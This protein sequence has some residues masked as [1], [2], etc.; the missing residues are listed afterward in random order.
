M[1]SPYRRDI[2]LLFATRPPYTSPSV[3]LPVP[4]FSLSSTQ[5]PPPPL[6][7]LWARRGC[8]EGAARRGLRGEGQGRCPA[9]ARALR[10]ARA[11][12]GGSSALRGEGAARGLQC[13]TARARRGGSTAR[14]RRANRKPTMDATALQYENQKLVQQLEAQ[15]SEMRTL[16]GKFKELRDEQCSYDNTLISLN[17]K[18]NQLIDDLVLLGVRAGGGLNNLQALDHEELSE[19]SLVSCPSEEIFL[20]R[21]LNSSNFRNNDENNLSEFV[22]E[23]LAL[24]YSTTV[25]L[26][27]SLQEAFAIQQARS[28]SLS[29]ALN[30]QNSNEG[31]DEGDFVPLF[32]CF[33]T[34]LH[35]LPITILLNCMFLNLDVIV[36]LEDHNE[37]LKEV[38]DNLHQAISI[39]NEKHGRYLDEIETFKSNHSRELQG[40]KCLSGE[41]EE[42]MA[43]LEESRR[44]LAV[45]Q[46]QRNGGSLVNTSA[47]NGVNGSVSTD[48]SSDKGT[49]WRDL[50]DAVEEAKTLA[51]NR[52]FE[53]HETQEDNLILSKQLEDL[54]DQLKD[55]KYIFMS[56]PYT[57][58]SDQ[59]H[60]LNAE[61]ERHKGLVEVLQNEKDQFMQKEKEMLAKA[62]SVDSIKQSITTYKAKIEDLE[63]EIQKLMVEKNDLEIKIE[64]ALQDS[65]KKDFKDEIHVMASSLSKEMELLENQL[66][67]SKDAASEALAL[68]EEADYLR[69]LLAKKI[70]EQKEISDRYNTQVTEIKSLKA[71]IETVDQEK[72]ELQFI[73]DMLGKECS[74]S[75]PIAEIE[76]SENRARKQAEYLRKCLEEHNLELRVKAANEAESAC[77]QR[78]SIAEVE[79]EDLRDKVDASE[80][81]VLKLK[82]SIR[83][84]EA[85]GD[86]HIS[87][88]ETI[89]Q[90]YED[91]QTQNQHLLQQVADRDDFN[92]KL[93]SDSVKMK[94]AYGSLLSEK[95]MLQKQLQHVNSSLESSK[96]K[97]TG[98]E[99]QMKTYVAQAMKSSSENRHLAISLERT[100]LELSDA[101][102]EYKYLRSAA[103]SAEKEYEINQKK[104]AELKMELER[105]RSERR[106]LEEEYEENARQFSS[107][108]FASTD[109]KRL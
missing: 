45:L 41:L 89:G 34:A 82:E 55:E 102:K 36:A 5:P 11:R 53:L 97:I 38:V 61:I 71:L 77:Q 12:R 2:F 90:A 51:A 21:L 23:A 46:L 17:K 80:R 57:I 13:S 35:Y 52:L 79:L 78:L 98:G 92:I 59:L 73:V 72:Q 4:N 3:L 108:G 33:Y 48:K 85:E 50:K 88:I 9:R 32:I 94:Q 103:G 28:E 96:Q 10:A 109:R 76:E 47:P 42:S 27:K 100:M 19:E 26:M 14:A 30:G 81:D 91:M 74:E 29:L 37:Y 101:E 107:V 39:I 69:T 56:K 67:R 7:G 49:G 18:W 87:E 8:S 16:E 70:D 99:E 83:I 106:K 22:E 58:L 54:Q 75:R 63:H 105:E 25:T 40:I 60:H 68:R 24:R 84:K 43:E 20:F 1:A 15:K 66:N 95:H 64:E 104:L 65:G 44:K 62:E 31:K 93:V 86:G 6:S